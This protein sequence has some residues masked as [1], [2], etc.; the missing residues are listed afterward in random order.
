MQIIDSILKKT[1]IINKLTEVRKSDLV[2]TYVGAGIGEKVLSLYTLSKEDKS[3][4]IFIAKD[5]V[6]LNEIRN[7]LND[8]SVKYVDVDINLN[9]PV[10][11]K[12]KNYNK[13]E[14][15]SSLYSFLTTE[16]KILLLTP[17]SLLYKFYSKLD[18]NNIIKI[19]K[20]FNLGLSGLIQ[21]LTEI[22]YK[23]CEKIEKRCEFSLKG[24]ILDIFLPNYDNPIRIDFFGD[25]IENLY[26]FD[27]N[28]M[29]K[30]ENL[31]SVNIFPLIY[32]NKNEE[33]KEELVQA[34]KNSL[35][36]LNLNA[37]A[38]MNAHILCNEVCDAIKENLIDLDDEFLLPFYKNVYSI[39]DLFDNATVVVSEPKKVYEDLCDIHKSFSAG[40]YDLYQNGELYSEH[41]KFIFEPDDAVKFSS[42]LIFSSVQQKVFKS[43][44]LD[45]IRT[46]GARN[47]CFDYKSL[48]N[49]LKIYEKSSYKVVIFAGSEESK[50][51]ISEFLLKSNISPSDQIVYNN[52]FQCVVSDNV[53]SK[54]FSFLD[55]GYIAIG[56]D[57]IVRR[58][59]KREVSN[60]S[61]KKHKV[62]YLPKV[63]DYVVHEVHG[64][65]KCI[66]LSKL[67]LNG[68]E[69]DYFV[70]E[71]LGGDKLYLPTEYADLLSAYMG[72]DKN[73]K[74]N[75][76]GGEQFAKIKEKV[77]ESVSK[78]AVDLIKV[79]SEREHSKGFVY[80]EDNYLMNA[81]E[82]AFIYEE[83]DDQLTAIEDI[84]KDMQGTKIMDRLIC[85]DVGYGK[86]EVAL[87]AIYKAIC[88]GKQVAFLCPT[89]IL[90]EQHYKTAKERFKD[91]FVNVAVLNRFKT[92]KQ[93]EQILN[94]VVLGKVDL[95]IGTH[96][97]LSSDVQ[98]KDL[99]LLVLDEE[100]RFGVA[101][102]EKIK[103]LKKNVDVL[104]LSATPIPRTLN[105]ALT[106][107]RDISIIET[108]PKERIPVKTFVV[109][110][111]DGLIADVCKKEIA[112]GGQVLFVYNRVETIYSQLE[113]LK[114]LLPNARIGVAHGQMPEKILEQTFLNL[115]NGEYDVLIATTLIESGV[116]LPL[117]NTLIVVDAD[118]LG[119]S[120]LYQLRGRVGRSDR[121][122]YAYFM[123]NSS[124][125]LTSDAYKRL[126]AILEYTEF[127]SGFKIAM[128]DLEIRGAG[129]VLGKEQHGH[130]QKVGYD[131][132]CKILDSAIKELK[133]EKIKNINPIKIDISI[134]AGISS[135]YVK[136]EEE[137]IKLYSDI[138]LISSDLEYNNMLKI[139]QQTYGEVPQPTINLLNIAYLKNL[140]IK[141]NVKRILV[142]KNAC[143]IYLYKEKQIMSE[144]MNKALINNNGYLA[145]EDVP[146]VKFELQQASLEQK[147]EFLINFLKDSLN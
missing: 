92:K 101:D 111:T 41:L 94:D 65:G 12:F 95:L 79:Y 43:N 21:K 128:R 39:I 18:I 113:R 82:D 30:I 32:F 133:G 121:I 120:E 89:T 66:A 51:S 138:S 144:K 76:I 147:V 96:R 77:K 46:I 42:K 67:N 139:L 123:Y 109:E 44:V 86:T 129:N 27:I 141:N 53:F 125:A 137:R 50:K 118:R 16:T 55:S 72:G 112:R 33:E 38:L 87:R 130:L 47:Y 5:S 37:D 60:K 98:F 28:L 59:K 105:M 61:Q 11:S 62:F 15:I 24:D 108:P 73:P 85:G 90:S 23:K 78:L 131:M 116:D 145:F 83:T 99:G 69:K 35:M 25:D 70:I 135:E 6:E 48:I 143:N 106:G 100:Q 49:D 1:N 117:A 56:T 31:D 122:A 127:G 54:S 136:S 91:F 45:Y 81:F 104:T 107:I 93:Q 75:K 29:E 22:G 80:S 9:N 19:S 36:N 134:S 13:V 58:N 84:K 2:L 3:K 20:E 132:Y 142:T 8:L 110:E 146:V 103:E 114:Q 40:I 34:I 52:K 74:L 88:D 126:D 14:I 115:Y 64:I 17:E 68:T 4:T 119:L 124:K 140:G 71:Y 57:D 26:S 97:L 63:G 102:K 7:G 10:F